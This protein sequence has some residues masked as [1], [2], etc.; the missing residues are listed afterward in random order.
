MNLLISRL[1]ACVLV[2]PLANIPLN[3]AKLVEEQPSHQ[4]VHWPMPQAQIEKAA[5]PMRSRGY[6]YIRTISSG[7]R[8]FVGEFHR[9]SDDLV[10]AIKCIFNC[11]S[12]EL[13]RA[14]LIAAALQQTGSAPRGLVPV[15]EVFA[16]SEEA[17]VGAIVMQRAAADL[18]Q[19]LLGEGPASDGDGDAATLL[20]KLERARMWL[21]DLIEGMA[22]CHKNDMLLMDIKPENVWI[23]TDGSAVHCDFEAALARNTPLYLTSAILAPKLNCS[24]RSAAVYQDYHRLAALRPAHTD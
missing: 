7:S 15:I 11:A 9:V 2:F 3:W 8:S 21:G 13:A 4:S 5:A 10:V 12:G 20:V 22:W 17:L 19:L 23:L 6:K 14:Q 18:H 1:T 24:D 16:V